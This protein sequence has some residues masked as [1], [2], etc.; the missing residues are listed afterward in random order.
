MNLN[1]VRNT[2]KEVKDQYGNYELDERGRRKPEGCHY[3]PEKRTIAMKADMT[4]DEY[5]DVLHH[6]L[7]HL[8]DHTLGFP[9][10]QPDFISAFNKAEKS[11][12]TSTPEGSQRLLNILDDAFSTGASFDRNVTD[13][14]SALTINNP[15]VVKRFDKENVANYKH[16]NDYWNAVFFDGTSQGK[17]QK[18]VFANLFAIETDNYR[19]SKNFVERW[20]PD[21]VEAFQSTGL[22]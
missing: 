11:I 13:I 20:F 1:Y 9:S 4:N 7:G 19:I 2:Y 15:V 18:E 8:V 6:E 10:S 12:D 21:L 5:V 22:R 17:R 16:K 3:N 14:L